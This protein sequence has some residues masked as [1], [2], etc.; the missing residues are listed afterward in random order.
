MFFPR[1]DTRILIIL[2]IVSFVSVYF[3]PAQLTR[4]I[5]LIIIFAAYHTKYDYV[6]LL[7]F[8]IISDAPG[9]LFSG[10]TFDAQRIPLYSLAPGISISFEEFFLILYIV[11]I[12]INA[13]IKYP[14]IFKKQFI[15]FY[16]IAGFYVVYGIL[17]GAGASELI[18]TWRAL[19]PWSLVL[20]VPAFIRDPETIKRLSLL[21]FPFVYINLISQL[22]SFTTGIPWDNMLRGVEFRFNLAIT[23]QG[24]TVRAS[25]GAWINLLAMTQA[26]YY[27]FEEKNKISKNY[28]ISIIIIAFISIFLSATRG[29]MIAFGIFII[30][31]FL[32]YGSGKQITKIFR[33][34]LISI[35]LLIILTS[36]F[37]QLDWQLRGATDRLRTVEQLAQG[38][39]TAGGTLGRLD[40]RGPRVLSKFYENPVFGWGF[41]KE[42]YRYRDGHIGHH[43]ILLNTGIVGY[44]YLNILFIFFLYKITQ[45]YI[46]NP[47]VS[48]ASLVYVLG[49]VSIF[50]IHSSSRAAWG[51]ETAH[52]LNDGAIKFYA[53]LFAAVNVIY[54]QTKNN[55]LEKNIS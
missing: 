25:S 13:K 7:W 21:L 22:H 10:S 46:K 48:K 42:Y 9:R 26:L 31:V 6:Y 47:S 1:K 41:S 34:G 19:I 52:G 2:L 45:L 43:N 33:F 39:I 12:I 35:L 16:I 44:L 54:I 40:K 29:W 53:F 8:F 4:I 38:D 23:E 27:Y 30:G 50:V 3:L 32:L 24:Q 14:F 55:L 17:L 5:F 49:L 11:K 51:F 36:A 28:L 20:I 15:V 18:Q 37:P